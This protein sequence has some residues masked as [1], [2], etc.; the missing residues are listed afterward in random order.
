MGIL[1]LV[2][3]AIAILALY[4]FRLASAW[5]KT[6]V[7]C[8]VLASY[9]NIFVSVVQ[10]FEKIAPLRALAPTQSEPPF[11][12]AQLAV[13]ALCVGLG[14][15]AARRFRDRTDLKAAAARGGA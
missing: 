4:A 11:A 13:L 15:A 8:A 12:I 10:T 1:S 5:R 6:Y 2:A 9:L 14:I 3:L 7:I